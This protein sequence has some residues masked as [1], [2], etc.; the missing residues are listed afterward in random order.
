MLPLFP[1]RRPRAGLAFSETAV[2]VVELAPRW[3]GANRSRCC[4]THPLPP[5]LLIPNPTGANIADVAE[6]ATHVRH[7]LRAVGQ[8]TMAVSVPM[9]CAHAALFA[10]ETLSDREED[11][12]AVLRWRFQQDEHLVLGDA[13]I[14]YRVYRGHGAPEKGASPTTVLAVAMPQAVLQPYLAALDQAGVIPALFSWSTL[15]LFDLAWPLMAPAEEMLFIHHSQRSWAA[16]AIR[17]E[18]PVFLRVKAGAFPQE[19]EL[20]TL[21]GTLQYYDDL[22]PHAAEGEGRKPSIMYRLS[23]DSLDLPEYQGDESVVQPLCGSAWGVRRAGLDW[24]KLPLQGHRPTNPSE[25]SALAA[26]LAT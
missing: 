16:I 23:E 24:S 5:G 2:S 15:Q 10:F 3:R 22:Y 21:L 25:W 19:A 17:K 13:A 20:E 9:V 4:A 11:R 14:A 12:L 8:R 6:L 7:V 1:V 26:V 18:L